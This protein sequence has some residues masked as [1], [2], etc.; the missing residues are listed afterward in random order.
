M[1]KPSPDHEIAIIGA[2]PCGVTAG[3]K[4]SQAG[5][6]DF[7]IIDRS[8]DAGG[9]WHNNC[10]PGV[11]V[12]TPAVVF[13]FAFS[14]NKAWSRVFAP[15]QEVKDNV[16]RV[17]D[18]Y[19][20][21]PNL[22]FNTNVVR[23]VWDDENHFWRLHTESGDVI[24]ARYV[25]T[26]VG[27]FPQM[28]D[29]HIPGIE[30]FAGKIQ[31][32]AHWDTSFDY[33]GKRVAV[34]GTGATGVQL[35]PAIA[36]DVASLEVY[37]RTPI[38]AFP[39]PDFPIPAAI[40][41]VMASKTAA[42]AYYY[43]VT[44]VALDFVIIPLLH[45]PDSLVRVL[46]PRMDAAARFAHRAW[47]NLTVDDPAT[48][49]ALQ[50]PHGVI[51]KR[52]TVSNRYHRAFNRDNVDLVTTPIERITAKGIQTSDGVEHELDMIVLATGHDSFADPEYYAPGTVVGRNGFDMGEF[53]A[54]NG[55]QAYQ[56]M[57]VPNVPNRW[58]LAGPYSFGVVP[59]V[60][61][62]A[63]TE[64]IA[65]TINAAKA[66][67]HTRIEVDPE[68]HDRNH[69]TTLRRMRHIEYY[70]NVVHKGRSTYYINSQG[71]M[72]FLKVTGWRELMRNAKVAPL[73]DY[74]HD[75]AV[76]TPEREPVQIA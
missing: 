21:R 34:I 29:P 68:V 45:A 52:P 64:S 70:F 38:F 56:G 72:A 14:R 69:R 13:D 61:A 25:I 40:S 8:T 23:H 15:G 6:R 76:A 27:Q 41:Q 73:A 36:P 31:E 12:D 59:H 19:G 7:V 24:T 42:K 1:S 75:A 62:E 2:G 30:D 50:P 63:M 11:G 17:I 66:V 3:A 51:T 5:L 71:R 60:T 57:C 47:L 35:I 44:V 16:L 37:Q 4:L 65:A 55:V 67:G 10:Y 33:T 58:M 28:R 20:M 22:R 46:F 9:T 39:K 54:E 32:S 26:A 18:E 49:Q 74:V 43:A 53:F 48:R